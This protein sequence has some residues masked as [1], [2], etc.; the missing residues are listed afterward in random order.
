M[1]PTTSTGTVVASVGLAGLLTAAFGNIAADV[2]MVVLASVA[3]SVINMSGKRTH[4]H[5][6]SLMFLG[7]A[8]L[9]SLVLAWALASLLAS[10]SPSMASP[11]T[12]TIISFLIGANAKRL[13]K[14]AESATARLEQKFGG[15][16]ES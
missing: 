7:G 8:I 4:T 11:Y 5:L 13:K 14:I 2:M 15:S 9:T 3:G 16:H 6:E 10:I 12:P 1:E